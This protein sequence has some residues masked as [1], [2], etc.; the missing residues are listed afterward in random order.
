MPAPSAPAIETHGL[1][2]RFG[3]LVAVDAID[4]VVQRGDVLGFLGPNGAGK[5]TTIRML[6]GLIRPDAGDALVFGHDPAKHPVA[7]LRSGAGFVEAPTF[8]DYLSGRM[9]LELLAG[10]DGGDG[11]SR[12]DDVLETVGLLGR[13]GD[14]VRGYSHG[15]KQRL[16]VAA[17]LLRDPDLI[18]LDEP[19]TGL[20]PPAMRDMRNLVRRLADSGRTV[21]LSSHQMNEVEEICTRVAIIRDGRILF[22]GATDELIERGARPWIRLATSDQTRAT[23]LV[24]A[25]DGLSTRPGEDGELLLTG[26]QHAIDQLSVALG[27]DGVAIR[28]LVP[29]RMSLE[30]AFFR[31]LD[32]RVPSA[33]EA[34]ERAAPAESAPATARNDPKPAAGDGSE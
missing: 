5:T 1:T 14:R 12:I 6:L 30:Q 8:Y 25:A 10:L 32:D 15:M 21:L 34:P 33:E 29:Q 11:R 16:G 17:T 22:D 7:A 13:E 23:Q 31:L 9:N 28:A 19:T 3:D 20:D 2:K 18:I 27:R 26:E 24:A 4:L